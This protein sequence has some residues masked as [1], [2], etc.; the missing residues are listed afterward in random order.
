MANSGE[1]SVLK[2]RNDP[3]TPVLGAALTATDLML[4]IPSRLVS[5]LDTPRPRAPDERRLAGAALRLGHRKPCRKLLQDLSRDRCDIERHCF[6]ERI[7]AQRF[8]LA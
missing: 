1:R 6:D 2:A 8:E 7:K 5:S 3:W 4:P